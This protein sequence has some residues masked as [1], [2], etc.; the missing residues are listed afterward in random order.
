MRRLLALTVLFLDCGS[1][2]A[3]PAG[4]DVDVES[5][6]DLALNEHSVILTR[7]SGAPK[8]IVMRQGL[9][10]RMIA[11][12]AIDNAIEYRHGGKPLDLLR[13]EPDH[14]GRQGRD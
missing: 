4:C 10:Q 8:A 7:D 11:L 14:G 6:Y 13:V 9:C 5:D 2:L 3:H 12:D 1:A